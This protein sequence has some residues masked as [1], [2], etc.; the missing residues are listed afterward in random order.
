MNTGSFLWQ[1]AAEKQTNESKTKLAEG[2]IVPFNFDKSTGIIK[3]DKA[4]FRISNGN[5]VKEGKV[6]LDY[7]ENFQVI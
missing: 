2:G 7:R 3:F 1:R 5:T 6:M 4:Q